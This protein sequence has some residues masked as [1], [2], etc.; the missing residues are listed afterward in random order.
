MQ[1]IVNHQLEA[2]NRKPINMI[3]K[4]DLKGRKGKI[5]AVSALSGSRFN[6]PTTVADDDVFKR[7]PQYRW[8][9]L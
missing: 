9:W 7:L 5:A 8:C 1:P 4:S 6:I 3:N 2:T